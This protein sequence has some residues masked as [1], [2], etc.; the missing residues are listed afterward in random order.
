MMAIDGYW[1]RVNHHERQ[2]HRVIIDRQEALLRETGE[3][4]R[5]LAGERWGTVVI[6]DSL[7]GRCEVVGRWRLS[8]AVGFTHK[9]W[10]WRFQDGSGN[11]GGWNCGSIIRTATAIHGRSWSVPIPRSQHRCGWTSLDD[12]DESSLL[13]EITPSDSRD[14]MSW[15]HRKV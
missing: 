11:L 1:P 14:S 2:R 9:W 6:C 3:A 10:C 7:W 8:I 4:E 13:A 15:G 12:P 5:S